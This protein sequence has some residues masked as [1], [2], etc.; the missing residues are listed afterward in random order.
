M[1]IGNV[2]R[3][4][5]WF[6][7]LSLSM[8]TA[9]LAGMDAA[10]GVDKKLLA[11]AQTQGKVIEFLEGASAA[12]LTFA[13]APMEEQRKMLLF[14]AEDVQGGIDHFKRLIAGWKERRASHGWPDGTSRAASTK[15]P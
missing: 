11:L 15:R 1:D 10:N 6:V 13:S 7:G 3:F 4:Q 12:L 9:A 5:P 2:S 8:K 14:A